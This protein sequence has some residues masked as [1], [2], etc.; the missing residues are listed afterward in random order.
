MA[1]NT[2]L[3]ENKGETKMIAHRGVSGLERE[4]TCPAF[5]AAG[6]KTYYGIETD[7]HYTKD[8]RFVVCHDSNLSRVAGVDMI[9]EETDFD[10]IRAVRFTDIHGDVPRNDIFIPTLEEYLHICRKYGKEAILEIKGSWSDAYTA[11]LVESVTA[12]EMIENTTFISFA[13]E[14]CL[15]VRKAYPAAKVQFLAG[16]DP[17]ISVAFC[18]ENGMDADFHVDLITKETVEAIHKA[19]HTVNCWTVNTIDIAERVKASGVDMI[20]TNILE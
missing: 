13:K 11:R 19:G 3:F 9:I 12:A 18:I 10:E 8:G 1:L 5:V 16:K 7:V 2:I 15:G 6:V 20:T 14:S 4:N 17:E